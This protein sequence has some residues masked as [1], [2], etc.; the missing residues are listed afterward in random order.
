MGI[1]ISVYQQLA[2]RQALDLVGGATESIFPKAEALILSGV[3]FVEA[4]EHVVSQQRK[5]KYFSLMDWIF[6]ELHPE[7]QPGCSRFYIGGGKPLRELLTIDEVIE[8]GNQLV[9]A[10][11]VAK[12][13]HE[14]KIKGLDWES[15]RI[16]VEEA[17]F[18]AS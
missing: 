7:Y 2:V 13:H 14:Q 10:L 18:N 12:N 16:D 1:K 9:V 17:V 15:F 11:H 3:G 6:C 4:L 5:R 8:Y